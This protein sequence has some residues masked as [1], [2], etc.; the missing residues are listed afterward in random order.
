[1]AADPFAAAAQAFQS[2]RYAEAE[3][4]ARQALAAAP[5]RA[6]AAHLLG[7]ALFQQGRPDEALSE[8]RRAVALAPDSDAAHNDLARILFERGEL[9]EAERHCR[10]AVELNAR[11]AMAYNNLGNILRA[12]GLAA[13]AEAAYRRARELDSR[14]PLAPYNLGMLLAARGDYAGAVE[15]LLAAVRLA[16]G[17][18]ACWQALADAIAPLRFSGPEPGAAR[19]IAVCLSHPG[20]DG[21]RLAE[22]A[23][24]LLRSDP[25]FETQ[26]LSV[27]GEPLGLALLENAIVPDWD[28]ERRVAAL[29][30]GLLLAWAEGSFAREPPSERFVCA[31]A[32]QCFLAEYAHEES[33]DETGL[34]ARLRDSVTVVAAPDDAGWRLACALLGAY[35]P[36]AA[37]S[38]LHSLRRDGEGPFLALVRRQIAEPLEERR[39]GVQ[40]PA[41]TPIRDAGSLAVR[42]QYEANPY[43]RWLRPPSLVGAHPLALKVAAFRRF[44]PGEVPST[45]AILVAGCG[46][47]RHAALTALMHPGSRILAVDLSRAS[48]GYAARRARELGIGNVEFAQADILELAALEERFDLIE[49]A[50]VLH[51]LDEPLAGWRVLRGLLRPGGFMQLALYSELG[52]RGVS[53]ARQLIAGLGHAP[54]APGMRAARAAIAALP[55]DHPARA[56]MDSLDFWSLSGCRDLLF[57]A[58]ERRFT[59]SRIA[60]CVAALG[61]EFLGFEFDDSAAAHAILGRLGSQSAGVSLGEWERFE[62]E[63]PDTFSSMY[64]FWVRRPR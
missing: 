36:L 58:R 5:R 17:E 56:V 55:A 34:V 7:V 47:G 53:A 45:P 41:L 46:T 54:D 61:V 63:R 16:P 62:Q 11:N 60:E 4:L 28:F 40:F 59:I 31:L 14:L 57:H 33:A 49:C 8:L 42:E 24:S 12:Q 51:H 22:A 13:D 64:Q 6:Q 25:C 38:T 44:E 2:G 48:L 1:M 20:I 29:R 23:L 27:L 32:Q 3:R 15:S 50:G 43:P 10:R 35:R 19:D 26:T 18:A 21:S 39:T 30:R 9:G 37:I 52:R